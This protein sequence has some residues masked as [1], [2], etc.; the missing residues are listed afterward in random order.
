MKQQL[1]R[2]RKAKTEIKERGILNFFVT[3]DY[4][5]IGTQGLGGI[6]LDEYSEEHKCRIGTAYGCE[7]LR[8]LLLTLD[9]D[10]LSEAKG[11]MIW[12]I[13]EGSGLSFKPRG[14]KQ[15]KL[16]GGK[17]MIFDDIAKEFIK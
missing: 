6:S 17:E 10:D 8:Q 2:V 15:L 11:K 13:G 9:V 16:D 14:I 12:V 1:A 4:E 5:D 7:M 3:V